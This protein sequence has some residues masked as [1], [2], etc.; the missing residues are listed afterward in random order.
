MK[1]DK[2]VTVVITTYKRKVEQISKGI[3]SVLKQTYSN[4]ELIIVDDSPDNF[5]WRNDVKRYCEE[6]SKRD[7]RVNYVQQPEN[8]GACVARNRGLGLA[9]GEFISFLDDDDVYVT[10]RIEKMI[11]LF[12]EN[13]VLAYSGSVIINKKINTKKYYF[14]ENESRKKDI[15]K[16]IMK[17][18]FIGSTSLV[19]VR[20][21]ALRKIGGFDPQMVAFQD[22]DVWI[23]MAK[24]GMLSYTT[25]PLVNYYVYSGE[26]ITNNP[27]K[28]LQALHRL[29]RKN[30]DYIDG[31]ADV[32]LA[33]TIYEMRLEIQNKDWRKGLKLYFK[34]IGMQKSKL[35]TNLY[36][37]KSFARLIF[38]EKI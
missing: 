7:L 6:I 2:L 34:I 37:L 23:R 12:K 26:R 4:L 20:T 8:M 28:R 9:K 18:N 30:K 5:E 38:K 1:K 32:L 25:E 24:E 36:M 31:N 13:V 14:N 29:N 19:M 16:E 10:N 11:P 27:Q 17:S 3:E 22:W 15:Q 33:R 21:S 35:I